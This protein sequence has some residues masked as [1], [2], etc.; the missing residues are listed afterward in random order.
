MAPLFGLTGGIACGKSTVSARLAALGAV[1]IDADRIARDVVVPGSPGLAELV[2]TFGTSILAADGTLDRAALGARIFGDAD[3]RGR[4]NGILHPR[5]AQLSMER[6]LAARAS[7]VPAVFYDAALLF[8]SGRAE[9]FRPVIVVTAPV[10]VQ[11][12]RVMARDGLTEAEAQ[13]RID[14][15]MPVAEKAAQADFVIDNGGTLEATLAQVDALWERWRR[16]CG[17]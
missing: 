16:P 3:A 14:A 1:A 12:Q 17:P 4:L 11:R 7:D 6:V 13:A 8:E 15:Q 5:I 2:K 10:D 9:F